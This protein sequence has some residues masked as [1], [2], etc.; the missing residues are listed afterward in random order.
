MK[1]RDAK[2]YLAEFPDDADFMH[3]NEA[4]KLVPLEHAMWWS[5]EKNIVAT[6]K[7]QSGTYQDGFYPVTQQND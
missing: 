6:S 7:E 4:N 3:I 1:V 2:K 5:K